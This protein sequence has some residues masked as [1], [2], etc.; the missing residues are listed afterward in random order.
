VTLQKEITTLEGETMIIW[1]RE[2]RRRRRKRRK[3]LLL[4][5]SRRPAILRHAVPREGEDQSVIPIPM[6]VALLSQEEDR[7]ALLHPLA[8]QVVEAAVRLRH[9][10][11]NPWLKLGLSLRP[12]EAAVVHLRRPH[13]RRLIH[14]RLKG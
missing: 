13:H 4:P 1:K 6:A 2:R 7:L 12:L 10:L 3:D 8:A 5:R 14:Q 11:T 9:L